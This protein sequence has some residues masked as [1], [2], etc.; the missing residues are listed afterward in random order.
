ML[1]IL[2]IV[3]LPWWRPPDPLTGRTGL[4]SYAPSGLA[5]ELRSTVTTGQ[6]VVVAQTWG[7]WFEWAVP[8]AAYFVDSRFELFP[9]AVWADYDAISGGDPAPL[10]SWLVDVVVA[11]PSWDAP[12]GWRA[13]YSDADGVIWVRDGQEALVTQ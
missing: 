2:I 7:S 9:A 5:Q 10:D 6:R 12:D 13:Q 11:S 3:A 4:L 8:Q 1:G